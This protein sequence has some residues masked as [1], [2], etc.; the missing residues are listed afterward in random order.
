MRGGYVLTGGGVCRV[1]MYS[2]GVVVVA[3][4]INVGF[5]EVVP[6]GVWAVYVLT[7][8]GVCGVGMY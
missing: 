8:G 1:F 3:D 2:L 4:L 5:T 6:C 7:G